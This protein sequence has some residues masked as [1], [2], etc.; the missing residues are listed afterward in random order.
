VV[1]ERDP[2][3]ADR[4]AVTV[5]VRPD[6]AGEV[7]RLYGGMRSALEEICAGYGPA[8][9]EV[10]ADFLGKVSEAGRTAA[11]DL[12]EAPPP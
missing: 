5:R 8:E 2:D 3:A 7:Y 6:R 10:I 9:L 4:R 1:R 12:V 11:A